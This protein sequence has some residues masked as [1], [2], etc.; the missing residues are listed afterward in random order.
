MRFRGGVKQEAMGLEGVLH[1]GE[2]RHR[3][4]EKVVGGNRL[5]V[6]VKRVWQGKHFN[7]NEVIRDIACTVPIGL[8]FLSVILWGRRKLSSETLFQHVDY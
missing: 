3:G 7:L 6:V 5:F 2:E 1:K 8:G 4:L